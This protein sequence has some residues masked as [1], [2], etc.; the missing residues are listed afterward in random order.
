MLS[1]QL[2]MRSGIKWAHRCTLRKAE[3]ALPGIIYVATRS[4]TERKRHLKGNPHA[5][6]HLESEQ[7]SQTGSLC[8]R[9]LMKATSL[10]TFG[11]P[12]ER[13]RSFGPTASPKSLS[14]WLLEQSSI[15][16]RSAVS[17]RTGSVQGVL[18][19]LERKRR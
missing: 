12:E 2:H 7:S 5:N 16:V 3:K 1:I 6:L 8:F 15:Y 11:P 10:Q 4:L 17:I 18:L 14:A 13:Y 19:S 9:L